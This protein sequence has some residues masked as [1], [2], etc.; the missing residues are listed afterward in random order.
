MKYIKTFEELNPRFSSREEQ[1]AYYRAKALE[2]P[3]ENRIISPDDLN[4][5]NLPDEIIDEMRKWDIIVKS[6]YSN[7]F[8]NSL[9]IDW[10][11]KPDGSYRVSD[12]WNFVS[13]DKKHCETTTKVP[14]NT[15]ISLGQYDASLGKYKILKTVIDKN[16]A[17]KIKDAE[18]RKKYLTSPEVI[19]AK[20]EFKRRVLNDEIF[21]EVTIGGK[22]YK[23]LVNKFSGNDLRIIDPNSREVLYTNNRLEDYVTLYDKD[24]NKVNNP[25]QEMKHIKTFES[26]FDR[27]RS[28]KNWYSKL[29]LNP[30]GSTKNINYKGMRLNISGFVLVKK[31][32]VDYYLDLI[33][34]ISQKWNLVDNLVELQSD[35]SKKN[36]IT[37]SVT[38]EPSVSDSSHRLIFRL[39]DTKEVDPD[40][41]IDIAGEIDRYVRSKIKGIN[42]VMKKNLG[43]GYL[44]YEI[45][46]NM[47]KTKRKILA[48]R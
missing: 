48:A 11:S 26:L 28:E 36:F 41:P 37:K 47:S 40:M 31:S 21:G 12:H 15:H 33:H 24:G 13:Q 22:L 3:I 30:D 6:P 44:S 10:S 23:G 7:S 9:E 35:Y 34:E 45:L 2:A 5:F 18:E 25:F 42:I 39:S 16:Y 14:T 19:E 1:K 32:L 20:K 46:V 43:A 38:F 4:K 27:F 17:K 29:E 8:Y